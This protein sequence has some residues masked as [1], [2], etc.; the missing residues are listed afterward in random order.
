[1]ELHDS[2]VVCCTAVR[3]LKILLGD[4]EKASWIPG[5]V[6]AEAVE[7]EE[8]TARSVSDIAPEPSVAQGSEPESD[9]L[10]DANVPRARREIPAR[11][12]GSRP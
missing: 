11:G 8:G 7:K 2:I 3:N 5:G 4:A 1:M 6:H 10:A 12:K 9:D